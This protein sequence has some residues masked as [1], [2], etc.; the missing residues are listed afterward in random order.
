MAADLAD[1]SHNEF[2]ELGGSAAAAVDVETGHAVVK[3]KLKRKKKKVTVA[4]DAPRSSL[5]RD[6]DSSVSTAS[7]SSENEQRDHHNNIPF[8]TELLLIGCVLAIYV[9]YFI[10]SILQERMYVF[11][12]CFLDVV[13]LKPVSSVFAACTSDDSF[14]FIEP[15]HDG[16]GSRRNSRSRCVCSWYSAVSTL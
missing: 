12:F 14:I 3:S 10:Y 1:T 7:P 13:V 2:D 4:P 11:Y 8:S 6:N 9:C 5:E 15:K 16:V